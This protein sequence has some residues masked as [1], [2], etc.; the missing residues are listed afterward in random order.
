MFICNLMRKK[1]SNSSI[2]YKTQYFVHSCLNF[3]KFTVSQDMCLY[4]QNKH[5]RFLTF[6]GFTGSLLLSYWVNIIYVY[7]MMTRYFPY[8]VRLCVVILFIVL[9]IRLIF[10]CLF[11]SHVLWSKMYDVLMFCTFERLIINLV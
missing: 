11:Y 10:F 2:W 6:G 7:L 8:V 9:F 1:S 5:H 3:H 4:C